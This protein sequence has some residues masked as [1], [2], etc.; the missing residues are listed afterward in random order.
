MSR[1]QKL[2]WIEERRDRLNN[3]PAVLGPNQQDWDGYQ[4]VEYLAYLDAQ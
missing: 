2:A 1:E 4:L 3:L